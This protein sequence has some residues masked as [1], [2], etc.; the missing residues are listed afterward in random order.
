MASTSVSSQH[1]MG[2][3]HLRAENIAASPSRSTKRPQPDSPFPVT[4]TK[5]HRQTGSYMPLTPRSSQLRSLDFGSPKRGRQRDETSDA[6]SPKR[7]R[8][9]NENQAG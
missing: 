8:R 4:P 3:V 1:S 9:G 6:P 2:H 5:R 7:V